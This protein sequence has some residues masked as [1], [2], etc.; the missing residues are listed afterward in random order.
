LDALPESGHG[1]VDEEDVFED[2][3]ADVQPPRH[4]Q[5]TA[6]G[7]SLA[8]NYLTA[9]PV[10]SKNY[11]TAQSGLG[12]QYGGSQYQP[13]NHGPYN[14]Y[15]GPNNGYN[16]PNN[17]YNGP[18]NG[19]G[20]PY[21]APVQFNG[22]P[23]PFAPPKSSRTS[24]QQGQQFPQAHAPQYP[25]SIQGTPRSNF[26]PR[27]SIPPSGPNERKRPHDEDDRNNASQRP[28]KKPGLESNTNLGWPFD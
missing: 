26:T 23:S 19:Y 4:P 1:S 7:H 10:L 9:Q 21:H 13:V 11:G 24:I 12:A 28:Y 22:Q 6:T 8:G 27:P 25:I 15:N 20:G 3:E 5:A 18:N 17:G 2:L 16:G 14:G